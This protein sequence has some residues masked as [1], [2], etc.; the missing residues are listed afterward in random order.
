MRSTSKG[1][2]AA[3]WVDDEAFLWND[4]RLGSPAPLAEVWCAPHLKLHQPKR[5]PTEVLFNPN[6]IV[7][8]R[9]LVDELKT[10][11][12]LEF[13][14]V[15]VDGQGFFFVLHVIAAIELPAGT[16]ARLAPPPSGNLVE[17][18]A[19][20]RNFEPPFSFFRI[21]QPPGSAA[22]ASGRT[23]KATYVSERGRDVIAS[24]AGDFLETERR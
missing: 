3:A 20:P 7:L 18:H 23:A 22:G 24:L 9:R 19:F 13:L 5:G 8:S 14:P 1:T 17:L 21:L 15:H 2:F 10:F 6:A 4:E 11:Q 16:R 12:E